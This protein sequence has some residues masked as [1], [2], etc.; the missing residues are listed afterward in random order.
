MSVTARPDG[1]YDVDPVDPYP[2]FA[3]MREHRPVYQD[4]AM[5]V[6]CVFR[7]HDVLRVLNPP[8]RPTAEDPILFSSETPAGPQRIPTQHSIISTDPPRQR[9]VRNL[10]TPAF[11]PKALRERYTARIVSVVDQLLDEA[12]ADG[13]MDVV[14]KLSYRVPIAVITDMLGLSSTD[15]STF[16]SWA[17]EVIERTAVGDQGIELH[18]PQLSEYL[19]Q[20]IE[21]R[22]RAPAAGASDIISLLVHGQPADGVA[23]SPEELLGNAELL[24]L[25]G[26]ETTAHLLTNVFRV[27][28]DLPEVQRELWRDPGLVS[29]MVEETLRFLSP[30]HAQTRRATTDLELGGQAIPANSMIVPLLSSANRDSEVFDRPEEFDLRRYADSAPNHAAFGFRGT[31]FCLGAPLARLEANLTLQRI[32]QRIERITA[33]P[34]VKRAALPRAFAPVPLVNGLRSLP[35]NF[36]A[37]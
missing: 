21:E 37:R 32:I 25:A 36:G 13:G 18:I 27:L 6:W 29:A 3:H 12:V 20:V 2:W 28:C 1:G 7:Y 33:V 15:S 16:Q 34:G 19:G 35:V 22:R 23:L 26:L 4:P 10:L 17:A 5:G 8:I 30:V 11:T 9:V 14:A 24:L 31:H